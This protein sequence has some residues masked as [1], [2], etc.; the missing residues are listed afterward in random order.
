M[1]TSKQGRNLRTKGGYS[2]FV[3]A[4]SSFFKCSKPVRRPG[5]IDVEASISNVLA[6]LHDPCLQ[7]LRF[8]K[9]LKLENGNNKRMLL[10]EYLN[11]T[12]FI[13]LISL[14]CFIHSLHWRT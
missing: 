13:I 3:L 2:R 8:P 6:P 1:R 4:S 5:E 11:L 10:T 14:I 7:V 9:A 12:N